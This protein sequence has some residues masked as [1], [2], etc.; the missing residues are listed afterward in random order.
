[1]SVLP[2]KLVKILEP[3]AAPFENRNLQKHESRTILRDEDLLLAHSIFTLPPIQPLEVIFT[4]IQILSVQTRYLWVLD[5]EGLKI[6]LEK[7]PCSSD[8]G[9]ACH[10]NITQGRKAYHG[11]ELWFHNE[12]EISLNF[13][14]G[15]YNTRTKEQDEA[16]MEYFQSL[17]IQVHL[18][19]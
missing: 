2:D 19:E 9:H 15:R 17:G 7:T 13:F 10:S 16:V 8:R 6:I 5:D 14:S 4:P 1:V 11:G 12:Q 3:L 18:L